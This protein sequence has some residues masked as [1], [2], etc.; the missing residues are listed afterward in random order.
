MG[1]VFI[2]EIVPEE[3]EALEQTGVRR[4]L[5]ADFFAEIM[6]GQC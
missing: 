6:T 3:G 2:R 4:K 1:Q 5:A